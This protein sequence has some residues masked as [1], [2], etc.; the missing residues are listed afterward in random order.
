MRLRDY[1]NDK[2]LEIFLDIIFIIF[3]FLVLIAFDTNLY[4]I[5]IIIFVALTIGTLKLFYD[6]QRRAN[7]YN[8]T[9]KILNN[10]DQKYLESQN[11]HLLFFWGQKDYAKNKRSHGKLAVKFTNK[12]EFI[13]LFKF[14]NI[15]DLKND[16]TKSKIRI[17]IVYS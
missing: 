13:P 17:C 6:F 1:L 9:T 3:V 12:S 16:K 5:F 15:L 4:L 7:F 2:V 14:K 10:L 11:P 8:E